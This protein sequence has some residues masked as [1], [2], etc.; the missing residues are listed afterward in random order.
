[1]KSLLLITYLFFCCSSLA[2]AQDISELQLNKHK[3]SKA[4]GFKFLDGDTHN[5]GSINYGTKHIHNFKFVN[6]GSDKLIINYVTSA[7][8]CA[9][10]EWPHMPVAPG[11]K[12]IIKVTFTATGHKGAFEKEISIKSNAETENGE[13]HLHIAGVI[14]SV[15]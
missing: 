10:P 6:T 8:G 5:F 15:K 4:P 14:D 12:G 9:I 3:P 1:M 7:C 2:V 13:Y 11:G